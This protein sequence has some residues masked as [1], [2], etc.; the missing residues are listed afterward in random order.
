MF[1]KA[2]F[3][4]MVFDESECDALYQGTTPLRMG[5]S[6]WCGSLAGIID[7]TCIYNRALSEEEIKAHFLGSRVPKVRQL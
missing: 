6:V 7:E 3:D 4:Q 1:D 5:K 2:Y